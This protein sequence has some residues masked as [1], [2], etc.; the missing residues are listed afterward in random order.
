MS[1]VIS[2]RDIS[3]NCGIEIEPY[4]RENDDAASIRKLSL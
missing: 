4:C 3:N 1:K 2:H